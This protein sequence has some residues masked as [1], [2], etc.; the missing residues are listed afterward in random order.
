MNPLVLRMGVVCGCP[1]KRVRPGKSRRL[2]H[3]GDNEE[4]IEISLSNYDPIIISPAWIGKL[5]AVAGYS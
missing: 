2:W 5:L 4:I 3:C 1:E